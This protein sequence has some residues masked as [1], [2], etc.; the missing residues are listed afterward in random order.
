[1]IDIANQEQAERWNSGDDAGHWITNQASHDRMLEPFM[2]MILEA[3]AI[4]AGDRVLDVGC[5]C[6]A[7]TRAAA[8]RAAEGAVTGI[9]LSAAMLE[10]GR[11]DAAA[12][13]LSNVS[14]I[15]GD[16][17]V[18]PFEPGGFDVV[19]SRFGLMF[20]ADP[21]AAFTNLRTAAARGGR[22]VFVCWQPAAANEWLLVPGAALAEHL[23]VPE[24]P[25][26]N[27]PGM[28]G[29]ADPDRVRTILTD[30]GWSGVE[31]IPTRTPMLIGGGGTVEDAVE[32]VRT[33]SQGRT[34]L[35]GADPDTA[36]RAIE[37]LRAALSAY[38]DPDGVRLNAAVW[39]V[40]AQA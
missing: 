31:V 12:T 23:P 21:I 37:S 11:A 1:V 13:G 38:A 6:G 18:F 27:A 15:Q 28:F 14:F 33:G 4:G 40:G 25:P 29:L 39:L 24:P 30:A 22:L 8:A 16:A 26:A 36:A 35:S 17:Q 7:T 3:A 5:G 34:V 10:R 20:F 32:F 2:A 9:D 19:I